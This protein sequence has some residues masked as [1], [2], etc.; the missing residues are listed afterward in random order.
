MSDFFRDRLDK[1]KHIILY[2][3]LCQD[4]LK[5]YISHEISAMCPYCVAARHP[6]NDE[7]DLYVKE[8][9]K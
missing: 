5:P 3:Y 6:A 8:E 2:T 4:S 9:E 1:D 7:V